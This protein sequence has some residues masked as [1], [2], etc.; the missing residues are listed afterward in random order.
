MK[1]LYD[2]LG[3]NDTPT[4]EKCAMLQNMWHNQTGKYIGYYK[5]L[6]GSAI[7][8]SDIIEVIKGQWCI[9]MAI[10]DND[11]LTKE[12]LTEL[13]PDHPPQGTI[14][15]YLEKNYTEIYREG[16]TKFNQPV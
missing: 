3:W 13:F 15:S 8:F 16:I 9:G 5:S 14:L 10:F 2:I 1:T 6:E 7:G 4:E 12:K 11:G